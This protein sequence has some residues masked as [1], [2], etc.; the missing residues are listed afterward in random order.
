MALR[1]HP[2]V[3]GYILFS[4]FKKSA[5]IRS[6]FDVCAEERALNL[7]MTSSYLKTPVTCGR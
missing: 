6:V 1:P 3:A 2:H 4:V 5:S 7:G